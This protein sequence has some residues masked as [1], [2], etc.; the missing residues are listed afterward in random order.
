MSDNQSTLVQR[1]LDQLRSGNPSARDALVAH[2]SANLQRLARKMLTGF[3]SVGRWE[4]FEDV[5]QNAA[6]RLW[7]ALEE[8][9]PATSCHFYRLAAMQ[10]RRELLDLARHYGGPQGL[11]ANHESHAPGGTDTSWPGG[12]PIAGT[13]GPPV[14]AVWTEF[15]THVG[16][17]P[18]EELDVFD[19][20]FYQGLSHAEAAENLGISPATLRRRW[21]AARLSLQEK[22]QQA[23]PL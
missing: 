11:G 10:L 5:S 16:Q 21:L 14:L 8:V 20:L 1:H 18:Q 12:T 19:L 15:H 9:Q 3:P 23:L 2:V 6:L 17:L 7:R 13:D 22:M 4:Q